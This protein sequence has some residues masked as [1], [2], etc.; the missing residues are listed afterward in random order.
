MKKAIKITIGLIILSSLLTSGCLEA[1]ASP[2]PVSEGT[3]LN[4]YGI[5]PITLDPAVSGEMTSHE[6]IMQL[7]NG[8]VRLDDS[9]KPVPDI[10]ERWQVSADGRTY[11]FYLRQDVQFHEG[12]DVTAGDFKY[13]WERACDPA[14]GSKTAATYLGDI[15]GAKELLAGRATGI[16]GVKVIDDYTLQVTIDAPK[17]YFLA[18]LTYPTAFVVDR[19]NVITGEDWWRSPSGT[20]PF[21]LR[22]W[23]ENNFLVLEKN[24][25]Y[26]GN[27][28]KVDSVVF[29]L[30]SGVPMN[31]YETGE[32]D[33][34]GVSV[35]YI[36]KVTD[37]AGQFYQQ[38]QVAPELSFDYIGFNVTRP[39]F[40]DVNVRRAFT[41]A[42][43]KDRL[44]SLAF[45]GMLQRADG[46]LP[47]GMP[48]FND[49]LSGLSYDVERA[50]ELIAESEYGSISG[51]PAIAITTAGRG[52]LISPALEAIVS[53]WRQNLGVEV[54]VR[55][56]EPD[57]FLYHLREEK[58]EMFFM[59]W[60]ADYPHPQNFLDVLF[61]TGA[62]NNY[63]EYSSPEVDDLLDRANLE[64]DYDQS[65]ALYQQAEQVLVND[66]ACLP[67]WFG[68]NYILVKLYVEGYKLNPLGLVKLNRVA[69][70]PDEEGAI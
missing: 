57:R 36:D 63:S 52:G 14:T 10:A 58:D 7:Y 38:L 46:I 16:S 34:A 44:I 64:Q 60:V 15:V 67:L 9:L 26:Y 11:T 62:D 51:L 40:D 39:P 47:P 53:Q 4:L 48:G 54:E 69:V 50:K 65:M 1:P 33:V 59:G 17:S 49:K 21:K 32:V 61:H 12:R 3:V 6:Y 5:D 31:M 45:R 42:V 29:N 2:V 30:W 22:K 66:A 13:S 18:K 35:D 41:L 70:K 68:Q 19:D 43:D 55:Q 20:G 23:D 27:Q 24:R 25:D 56:L 28:A 37:P 8:L